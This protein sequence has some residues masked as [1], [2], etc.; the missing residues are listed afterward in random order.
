MFHTIKTKFNN[1]NINKKLL[2]SLIFFSICSSLILSSLTYFFSFTLFID[3]E[4][5]ETEQI[6]N[7][8]SYTIDDIAVQLNNSVMNF[9][10]TTA[11]Q[12][13]C[14]NIQFEKDDYATV[15]SELQTPFANLLNE[16]SSIDN[17]F[18]LDNRGNYYNI[19]TIGR[20]YEEDATALFNSI[21]ST[22]IQWHE[23]VANPL[24]QGAKEIIPVSY[25]FTI[26][27]GGFPFIPNADEPI[28]FKIFVTLDSN[29]IKEQLTAH[30]QNPYSFF[31]LCN[32]DG[33][34]INSQDNKHVTALRANTEFNDFIKQ[35]NHSNSETLTLNNED[36]ILSSRSMDLSGLKILNI[37]SYKELLLGTQ[38]LTTFMLF[39]V[40]FNFILSYFIAKMLS[41]QLSK[42]IF[43]LTESVSQLTANGYVPTFH[44]TYN[45]EIGSLTQSINRMCELINQQIAQIHIEEQEKQDAKSKM[46]LQQMN[47][48]FLYNTLEFIHLEILNNHTEN[49]L[50]MVENLGV[51][52]RSTLRAEHDLIPLEEEVKHA[53][54]YLE[55]V[56][57]RTQSTIPLL[58][59]I[60][61]DL[62]QKKV[63]RFI[64]QPCI[65]N[66]LIHAFKETCLI[67]PQL[68]IQAMEDNENIYI[69]IIDNGMGIDME[70]A[71]D[72]LYRKPSSAHIGLYNIYQRLQL[73][74][75]NNFSITF[76]SIPYFE[77]Y[78]CLTFPLK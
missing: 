38:E 72:S 33:E 43:K 67:S 2:I 68:T 70:K 46:L 24:Q 42:P 12:R 45:D 14:D 11:F 55:I 71:N 57:L 31:L 75:E 6:L 37:T 35:T 40:I 44:S 21:N 16:N 78:I 77:N 28:D 59:D 29:K 47:P 48:H 8:M 9:C 74:Y 60:P 64:L 4:K 32:T 34:I 66:S 5:R 62:S 19:A 26:T 13:L 10:S 65:E 36:Y 63:L 49:S 1:M 20:R 15:Y 41:S 73:Q 23:S 39:S 7:S 22:K 3:R 61:R 25:P 58:L 17:V 52:L 56:N 51:F 30:N 69:K 18:I 53:Q 50:K 27:S 76:H 54:T